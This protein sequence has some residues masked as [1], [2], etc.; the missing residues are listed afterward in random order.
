M[1]RKRN[2]TKSSGV[3]VAERRYGTGV[4]NIYSQNP[5]IPRPPGIS[6]FWQC[7]ICDDSTDQKVITT[8]VRGG[9]FSLEFLEILKRL[10]MYVACKIDGVSEFQ[11]LEAIDD[12]N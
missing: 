5:W 4:G 11:S 7:Q 8:V 9:S 2:H 6:A 10:Y 12:M 1:A 3:M